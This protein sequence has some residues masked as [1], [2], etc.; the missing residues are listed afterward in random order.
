[1]GLLYFFASFLFFFYLIPFLIGYVLGRG[2][3]VGVPARGG[4]IVLAFY[5]GWMLLTWLQEGYAPVTL[6]RLVSLE[7]PI[8][9]GELFYLF[10]HLIL[11]LMTFYVV[12]RGAVR[13]TRLGCA[14]W[15]KKE[16]MFL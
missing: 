8:A 1:M 11:I 16:G 4:G 2:W 5:A 3:N 15:V 9:R 14:R 7:Q 10:N 6:S 12:Y 13:G